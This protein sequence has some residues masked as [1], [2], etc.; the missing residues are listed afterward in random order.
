MNPSIKN[1]RMHQVGATALAAICFF[2]IGCRRESHSAVKPPEPAPAETIAAPPAASVVVNASFEQGADGKPSG[3][4]G[5]GNVVWGEGEGASGSRF[6]ALRSDNGPVNHAA[7]GGEPGWRSEPVNLVP[8]TAYELRFRCRYRPEVLFT[9]SQVFAGPECAR[10][11]IG[12][13]ASEVVSPFRSYSVRFV[14]P[15][16]PQRIFLGAFQLKGSIEYDD[17][18][19]FPI[20]LAQS[21][22]DGVL[23]GEGESITGNRY[24][25]K[26]PFEI[27]AFRNVSRALVHRFASL[28]AFGFDKTE[29]VL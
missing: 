22:V 17:I 1:H 29:S 16:E 25:F 28:C 2:H 11:L 21:S 15:A 23:L 9:S 13:D 6:A 12:L 19:L 5:T 26:A 18:E 4:T 27:K 7:N 10:Q 3:W 8:G 24:D 14:A 20:K